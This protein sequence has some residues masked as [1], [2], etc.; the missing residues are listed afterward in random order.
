MSDILARCDLCGHLLPRR[1]LTCC[2]LCSLSL[3]AYDL[4][5]HACT[6]KGRRC[7]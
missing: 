3:C 4:A 5:R 7:Q 2:P 1:D 6:G